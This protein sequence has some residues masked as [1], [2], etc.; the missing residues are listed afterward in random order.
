MNGVDAGVL[1]LILVMGIIGWQR[2]VLSSASSLAGFALGLFVATHLGRVLLAGSR[3]DPSIAI[4]SVVIALVFA[5]GVS[6]L[7][8]HVLEPAKDRLH[9][10]PQA[11]IVDRT[12]GSVVAM[13]LGIVLLWLAAS[14]IVAAPSLRM[15]RQHVFGSAII[16]TV[17]AV[18]PAPEAILGV[19]SRY[20]P[21]PQLRGP[22]ISGIEIPDSRTSDV[23]AVVG[24]GQSVVRV[25]GEA[26]GF[27][28][29]G[30]GWVAAPDLVVTNAH[31]VAGEVATLVQP[32]GQGAGR[33]ASVVWFDPESD[34]AVLR[35]PD[36]HLAPL[37]VR[38][39]R[40]EAS[41][42]GAIL[43]Y[44]EN[45]PFNIRAVRV[46][47]TGI[48]ATTDITGGRE[49]RRNV[50]AFR[51]IVRHG[52]SGGPLIDE[53]G[54]V[55][56]TVFAAAVGGAHGGYAIPVSEIRPVITAGPT[57]PVSTGACVA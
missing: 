1:L 20:D 14:A 21:L 49:V 23:P 52:N 24:A 7:V 41:R 53:T 47:S 35:I 29:T 2:G 4:W 30:S 16:R 32:G 57:Q 31:V 56:A 48:V 18:M 38:L 28:L 51:G 26:C 34:L 10:H 42:S 5:L 46:G 54:A 36:L 55:I 3:S 12:L 40:P 17:A 39:E 45:G 50:T 43:G 22:S 11:A 33:V 9:E 8:E 37:P 15:L 44:P 25:V 27:Q 6:A 13:L 19:I